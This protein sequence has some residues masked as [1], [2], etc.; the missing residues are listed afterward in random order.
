MV[1]L[2]KTTPQEQEKLLANERH[3]FCTY[4]GAAEGLHWGKL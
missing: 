4:L 1:T 3:F 2:I